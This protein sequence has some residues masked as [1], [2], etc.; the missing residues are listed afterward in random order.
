MIMETKD[1]NQLIKYR[2]EQARDTVQV[3]A[4]LIEHNKLPVAVNRIYYGIFLFTSCF[5]FEV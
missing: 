3:V 4:L 1:R 2:L 5:G